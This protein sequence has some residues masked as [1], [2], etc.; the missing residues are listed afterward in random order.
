MTREEFKQQAR[1]FFREQLEKDAQAI[2]AKRQHPTTESAEIV[3]PTE[4]DIHTAH[5]E[6]WS[7]FI[8]YNKEH[9]GIYASSGVTL[10]DWLGKRVLGIKGVSV[11]VIA[12]K[13]VC[14]SEIYINTGNKEENKRIFDF[15]YAFRNE[16][17]PQIPEL[18]WQRLDDKDACRIRIDKPLSF[19]KPE[20]KEAIFDF[21]V[22]T[23]NQMVKAFAPY[24]D[25]Y[26]K[27]DIMPDVQPTEQ[28]TKQ[29]EPQTGWDKLKT[30]FRRK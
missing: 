4:K 25:H 19:L 2:L 22:T 21:F 8:R 15:Y 23:T 7:A 6:F 27:E 12:G 10:H 29:L 3:A 24:G 28:P 9:N 20:N 11:N 13:K 1:R 14:R 5:E 26:G 18:I 16:I 17:N 30:L